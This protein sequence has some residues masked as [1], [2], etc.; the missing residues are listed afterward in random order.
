MAEIYYPSKK[1]TLELLLTVPQGFQ[2]EF[3]NNEKATLFLKFDMAMLIAIIK[4][5]GLRFKLLNPVDNQVT[6]LVEILDN[7]SNPFYIESTTKNKDNLFHPDVDLL[8]ALKELK[9]SL[10][11][12]LT[13]P[14]YGFSTTLD[15]NVDNYKTWL[16][17]IRDTNPDVRNKEF[18]IDIKNRD[19][20]FDP[21]FISI[22]SVI[23]SGSSKLS[24]S[25][26]NIDDF[27]N[28]GKHGY[29]QES[30]I[31]HILQAHFILDKELFISPEYADGREFCDFIVLLERCYILI[32]SKFVISSKRTKEALQ[33]KK[34]VKQ[35]VR[36]HGD[37]LD[38]IVSLKD[39]NLQKELVK[40]KYPLKI[41][42]HNGAL[43]LDQKKCAAWLSY[44]NKMHLPMF[45]SINTFNHFINALYIKNSDHFKFDLEY[46]LFKFFE[47]YYFEDNQPDFLIFDQFKVE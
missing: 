1:E 8:L 2:L 6:Y 30:S 27:L 19:H 20:S 38:K 13:S 5:C 14:I 37:I 44:P 40:R 43:T 29:S 46:N 24:N 23:D 36:A 31:K 3:S 17:N 11:N 7:P 26:I 9:V 28:D 33:I 47:R 35:L 39:E 4:G 41:L 18:I 34:G 15:F 21:K 32:E 16:N 22:T 42:V 45:T 12:E 25:V 10:L